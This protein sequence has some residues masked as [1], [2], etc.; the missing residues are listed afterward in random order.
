VPSG[1]VR[2][3]QSELSEFYTDETNAAADV[4]TPIL[5]LRPSSTS[6]HKSQTSMPSSTAT[7]TFPPLNVSLNHI[8][9]PRPQP[10]EL[11]SP[12]TI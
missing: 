1:S 9:S 6:E 8:G 11:H 3:C 5:L 7:I 2:N 10:S 12:T 4:R